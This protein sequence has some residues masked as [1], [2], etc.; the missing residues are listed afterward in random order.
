MPKL[1][2][3][4]TCI[5]VALEVNILHRNLFILC[6][7][8]ICT[9][10]VGHAVAQLVEALRYKPEGCGFNSRLCHCNFSLTQ[11][12]RLRYGPE[13]DSAS[14]GNEYQECSLGVKAAGASGCQ[15]YHL[16]MSIV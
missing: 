14:N 5:F 7:K 4:V 15:P 6:I 8:H 1:W 13:V 9:L 16:H 3:W 11:F 2:L 10:Q 12:F